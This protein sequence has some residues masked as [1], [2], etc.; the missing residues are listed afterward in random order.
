MLPT[1]ERQKGVDQNP[2]PAL[3]IL[4]SFNAAW[5]TVSEFNIEQKEGGF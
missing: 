4:M 1:L 2:R 5:A 3:A